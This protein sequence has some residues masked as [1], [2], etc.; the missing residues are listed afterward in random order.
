MS[1]KMKKRDTAIVVSIIALILAGVL[2]G[3]AACQGSLGSL[4]IGTPTTG[5]DTGTTTGGGGSGGG[6]ISPPVPPPASGPGITLSWDDTDAPWTGGETAVPDQGAVS[7]AI[8]DPSGG[9][10]GNVG[11][12]P[13]FAKAV[14]TNAPAGFEFLQWSFAPSGDPLKEDE[15]PINFGG[16]WNN[17]ARLPASSP[18]MSFG[19]DGS[20]TTTTPVT[21]YVW[22]CDSA[23]N[24]GTVS[25]SF[26]VNVTEKLAI[27]LFW[28]FEPDNY[29]VSAVYNERIGV[30]QE[31]STGATQNFPS[32]PE[33]AT[34]T[35]VLQGDTA[36]YD[37]LQW[38]F[39]DFNSGNPLYTA[40][41]LTLAQPVAGAHNE[42]VNIRYD[43]D[44]PQYGTSETPVYVRNCDINGN[45]GTLSAEFI[46]EVGP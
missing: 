32:D 12:K 9:G 2:A 7:W 10:G 6:T 27:V 21:V 33:I 38:S 34:V 14:L 16:E 1:I 4:N 11:A 22:N 19:F 30:K 35:A 46:L 25:V 15:G 8:Y 37:Y 3:L 41:M 13:A 26:D 43:Y 44:L 45:P 23:G 29:R 5:V 20:G 18:E 36:G 28:T 40:R 17:G 24:P 42:T 31:W 39:A